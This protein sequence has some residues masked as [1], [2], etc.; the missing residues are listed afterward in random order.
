[1]TANKERP[2]DRLK[3]IAARAD[4]KASLRK[5]NTLVYLMKHNPNDY[6]SLLG[7]GRIII[8]KRR[9]SG[10]FHDFESLTRYDLGEY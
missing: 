6:V 5:L 10:S 4:V 2:V 7:S 9:G 8:F 3:R 1:M